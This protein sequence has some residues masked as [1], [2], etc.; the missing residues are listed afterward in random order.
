MAFLRDRLTVSASHR[1]R[2]GKG[3]ARWSRGMLIPMGQRSAHVTPGLLRSLEDWSRAG[4]SSIAKWVRLIRHLRERP[5]V[6]QRLVRGRLLCGFTG[7]ESPR[8]GRRQEES[9]SRGFLAA[10]N[11]N[12]TLRGTLQHST[13]IPIRRLWLSGRLQWRSLRLRTLRHSGY[14][15]SR[16]ENSPLD[17]PTFASLGTT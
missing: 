11:Q 3:R 2:V 9:F 12:L 17:G 5:R 15:G 16:A 13:G 8:T 10:P 1:S 14:A 7:S 4:C 6:V